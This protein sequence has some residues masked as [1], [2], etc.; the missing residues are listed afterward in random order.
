MSEETNTA[1]IVLY[2][3]EGANVPV[4]VSYMQGTFWMPQR[5]IAEL[6]GKDKSTISRHLKNIFGEGELD[7]DSVVANIATTAADGKTY[8]TDF[9][10]LDAILAVGYRVN[11][12]QATR[13]IV[14]GRFAEFQR[15]Q[16][17]EWQND[18]EKM[19]RGLEER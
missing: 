13:F 1:Q 18:F 8:Q 19:A 7:R 10:S 16:D 14:R 6:F 5:R 2:Q 17:A 11:S 12:P 15:I 3:S 4:E 9:Y